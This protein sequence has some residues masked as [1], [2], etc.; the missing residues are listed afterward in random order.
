MAA[1]RKLFLT[2]AGELAHLLICDV[3]RGGLVAQFARSYAEQNGRQGL[4]SDRDRLPELESTIG[5]EALLVMTAEVHR[6]LPEA[7][8]AGRKGALRPEDANFL[9]AFYEEF[10][11]ALARGLRRS[12]A[13]ASAEAEEFRADLEMYSR[14]RGRAMA[15]ASAAAAG[16][17]PFPDRCAFLLDASMIEQARRASADFEKELLRTAARRFR[18][19]GQSRLSPTKAP[20]PRG[21]KL[22][23]RGSKSKPPGRAPKSAG[24]KKSAP[25]NRS[26]P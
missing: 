13:N 14:W 18:Q 4:L 16:E 3:G 12:P 8:Q 20:Q 15:A 2:H 25:R 22:P 19:L 5:R 7:F 26:K 21:E 17:S 6:L 11:E 24:R 9:E 23:P 10:L 1:T